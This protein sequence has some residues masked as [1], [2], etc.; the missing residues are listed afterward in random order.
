MSDHPNILLKI[1][2][3]AV[4]A[5]PLALW[6][7]ALLLRADFFGLAPMMIAAIILARPVVEWLSEPVTQL[8]YPG[9]RPERP[10]P[11]Y[12]IPESKRAKGMYEEAMAGLET[13]AEKYPQEPRAY[14]TMVEIAIVDLKDPERASSIYDRGMAILRKDTDRHALT[15]MYL[16]NCSRLTERPEWLKKEQERV[17]STQGIELTEPTVPEHFQSP[18]IRRE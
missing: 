13:I 8:F 15:Q 11:M 5:V 1:L 17:L 14:I 6:G 10:P 16:G 2:L 9:G 7:I 12:S 3:H 4:V 18:N